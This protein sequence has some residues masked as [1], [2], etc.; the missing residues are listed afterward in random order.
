ML[1]NPKIFSSKKYKGKIFLFK[2]SVP[3]FFLKTN[4]FLINFNYYQNDDGE[5]Q[6]KYGFII[7]ESVHDTLSEN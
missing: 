6:Q 4:F 1:D 7:S 5:M 2:I 3:S